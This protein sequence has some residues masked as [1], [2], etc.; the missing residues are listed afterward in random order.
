[1]NF[2]TKYFA[3]K[4]KNTTFALPNYTGKYKNI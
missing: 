1:M 4:F 3:N 2:F